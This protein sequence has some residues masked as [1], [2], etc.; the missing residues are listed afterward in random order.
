MLLNPLDGRNAGISTTNLRSRSIGS[1]LLVEDRVDRPL[2]HMGLFAMSPGLIWEQVKAGVRV[3]AVLAAGEQV[4]VEHSQKPW[5]PQREQSRGENLGQ[6]LRKPAG[7][8]HDDEFVPQGGVTDGQVDLP[9]RALMVPDGPETTLPKISQISVPSR[10]RK[11]QSGTHSLWV[12]RSFW[13]V[14][15]GRGDGVLRQQAVGVEPAHVGCRS[16]GVGVDG[17]HGAPVG[18]CRRPL[19]AVVGR[20]P[21]VSGGVAAGGLQ[22]RHWRGNGGRG[23]RKLP[24]FAGLC[25]VFELR[26]WFG[27]HLWCRLFHGQ[28]LE[29]CWQGWN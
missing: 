9:K 11:K 12:R 13:N 3:C 5:R 19:Q 29:C 14:E 10:R 2:L 23:L 6:S 8:D 25:R 17:Q 26:R 20:Q 18:G 27:N 4:P 7:I 28:H 15:A 16:C 21:W 22:R 1:S 24:P